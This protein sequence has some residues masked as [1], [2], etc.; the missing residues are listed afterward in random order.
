M[1]LL[2]LAVQIRSHKVLSV[3]GAMSNIRGYRSYRNVSRRAVINARKEIKLIFQVKMPME[4]NDELGM[5]IMV[6]KSRS[7]GFQSWSVSL[8]DALP[9][10]ESSSDPLSLE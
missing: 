10:E 8:P 7:L 6:P 4:V 9:L 2:Q 1:Y 5:G 3:D